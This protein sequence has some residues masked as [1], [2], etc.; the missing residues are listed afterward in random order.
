MHHCTATDMAPIDQQVRL[1]IGRWTALLSLGLVIH[2]LIYWCVAVWYQAQLE[3]G[4]LE[5]S[6]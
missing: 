3:T 2:V 4:R 6:N 1:D 5:G